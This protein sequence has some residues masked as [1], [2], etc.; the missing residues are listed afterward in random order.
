MGKQCNG[1]CGDEYPS[2]M[3]FEGNADKFY[4]AW[5]LGLDPVL[6][7]DFLDEMG[8]YEGTYNP[9][10]ITDMYWEEWKRE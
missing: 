6:D 5:C 9:Q 1:G 8:W 10:K 3:V 7:E 4:C 2:D